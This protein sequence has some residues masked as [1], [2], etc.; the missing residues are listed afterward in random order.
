VEPAVKAGRRPVAL[1]LRLLAWAVALVL[2]LV[3]TGW[4]ARVSGWLSGDRL[5][6]AFTGTGG[7]ERYM[8]VLALA[9][10]WALVTT[11]LVTLFLE[12]GR[13]LARRR[14]EVRATR[15]EAPR[16]ARRAPSPPVDA[17]FDDRGRAGAGGDGQRTRRAAR[18]GNW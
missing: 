7:M 3:I 18:R 10:A 4:V 11:L 17:S 5:V 12:G 2:G 1:P 14:D 15:G 13:V 16:R 8:R 9:P 6:D